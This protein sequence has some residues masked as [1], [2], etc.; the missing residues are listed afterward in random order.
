MS[1]NSNDAIYGILRELEKL[2]YNLEENNKLKAKQNEILT[3][4]L[5]DG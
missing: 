3:K 2:N 5:N 1:F 4:L